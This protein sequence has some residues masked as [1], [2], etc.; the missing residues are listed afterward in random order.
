M[1]RFR[2]LKQEDSHL[3]L[4]S[5]AL[6]KNNNVSLF[7]TLCLLPSEPILGVGGC[8]CVCESF[9]QNSNR[10]ESGD[11]LSSKGNAS[12]LPWPPHGSRFSP[13][14]WSYS[15]CLGVGLFAFASPPLPKSILVF[16]IF[17]LLSQFIGFSSNTCTNQPRYACPIPWPQ[18]EF[19]FTFLTSSSAKMTNTPC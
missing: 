19:L 3:G 9:S 15:F 6:S 4:H 7:R 16:A 11:A 2:V 17:A 13:A 14:H 1:S 18:L 10:F 8:V 12:S 5:D